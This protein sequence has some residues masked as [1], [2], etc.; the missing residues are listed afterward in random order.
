M[1]TE[2]NQNIGGWTANDGEE[3]TTGT[4]EECIDSVIA[5][6]ESDEAEDVYHENELVDMIHRFNWT[7]NHE[8]GNFEFS[9]FYIEEVV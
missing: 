2:E 1:I 3:I 7:K 6:L 4:R 8:K 9:G 5:W